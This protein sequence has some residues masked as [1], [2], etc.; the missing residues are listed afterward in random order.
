VDDV[1]P[2]TPSMTSLKQPQPTVSIVVAVK[3]NISGLQNLISA[4][5]GLLSTDTEV[6]IVD[7]G[8]NDGTAEWL[9]DLPVVPG[10]P[11]V[12]SVSATDSGIAEAWNRG[13]RLARG[14]WVLFLGADDHVTE[15]AVWRAAIERLHSLP[16]ECGVAAFPVR[17]VTPAGAIVADE[18]PSL[19]PGGRQ[20]P[21]VNAIPHQGAFHR[22]G[23]WEAHGDFDTSF[24]IAA[25]YEFLLRI[26]K[27]GREI[28]ACGGTPLVAMT[29]GGK[30]KRSPLVN[31]QEFRR[32][33]RLHD[34]RRSLVTECSEWGFAALRTAGAAVVGETIARRLADCGRRIRGLPPVWHLQ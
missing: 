32:A 23:L 20:F 19:G 16:P 17:I 21:A 25:D 30:S 1:D 24:A 33:R 18:Q 2:F 13:I 10:R 15:A 12:T 31:V 26:W 34:V 14:S 29:F 27:A 9:A 28:Q 11:L 7:G 3:C 4:I 8:S 6:I 22:R 5:N